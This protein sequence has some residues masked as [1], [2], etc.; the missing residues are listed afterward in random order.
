MSSFL[1]PQ[2]ASGTN[3]SEKCSTALLYIVHTQR[4]SLAFVSRV[5]EL[6]VSQGVD[7]YGK[8]EVGMIK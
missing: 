8:D 3:V 7:V 5:T 4:I 1:L 2:D 6:L